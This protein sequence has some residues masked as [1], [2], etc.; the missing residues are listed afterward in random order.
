MEVR[1]LKIRDVVTHVAQVSGL[2]WL[3]VEDPTTQAH[4]LIGQLPEKV[5]TKNKYRPY[6]T[7]F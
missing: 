5:T 1:D 3:V 6:G 7:T 4:R 2:D